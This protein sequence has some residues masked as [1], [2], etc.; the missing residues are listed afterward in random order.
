MAMLTGALVLSMGSVFNASTTNS[1]P[2]SN[3][4]VLPSVVVTASRPTHD[5]KADKAWQELERAEKDVPSLPIAFCWKLEFQTVRPDDAGKFLDNSGIPDELKK[6]DKARD[7][8]TR[9]PHYS[10]VWD[11]RIWEYENIVRAYS[12]MSFWDEAVVNLRQS[13][14]P[15]NP[16]VW[17]CT[18]LAPRLMTLEKLLL[19]NTNLTPSSQFRFRTNRVDRLAA[20]PEEDWMEAAQALR[21]DF[22]QEEHAYD[23][24]RRQIARS[25]EEKARGLAVD[26][27]GGPAPEEAKA[28][29]RT[30]LGQLD[31]KGKP[32][33]LRFTA[34][35]GR[36]VDTA[37]MRG[38]VVLI[39]FWEPDEILELLS[40]KA[41]FESFHTQGLE[42]IGITIGQTNSKARLKSLLK[43]QKVPWPQYFDGKGWDSDIARRF[44][45]Y[46]SPTLLLLD[47]KG[48]LREIDA[49]RVGFE[50]AANGAREKVAVVNAGN[51]PGS[52]EEKIKSLL[53]E[54]SQTP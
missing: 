52:L 41:R 2:G 32:V 13:G 11:A 24:L 10:K 34:L 30:V 50:F 20:G 44:G 46:E 43:A 6:A 42:M 7:F 22:P 5:P 21:M 40:E 3:V 8:Y 53:A 28:L 18:N 31:L 25:S 38:R 33:S 27:I 54:P 1:P 23:Y 15:A 16:Q 9:F 45:I 26:V 14:L 49:Q 37:G 36:K 4:E 29:M 39:S 19:E 48:N 51:P 17:S 47:K 35:D 12:L